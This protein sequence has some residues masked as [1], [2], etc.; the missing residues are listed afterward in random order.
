MEN[1]KVDVSIVIVSMNNITDLFLCLDC[2]IQ[3]THKVSYEIYVVAYLFTKNNLDLLEFKYPT[4]RIIESNEIRGYSENNNLA[5]RQVNNTYSIILND[6]TYF[7][8]PIIDS[9]VESFNKKPD[10]DFFSP[11]IADR[12]GLSSG[13]PPAR[14]YNYILNTLFR[15]NYLSKNDSKY[16]NQKGIYQTYNIAGCCFIVKTKVLKE[17]GFF[18]EHYFFCPEDL[19]LSTL[20]N[21]RGYK[22]YVNSSDVIHHIQGETI[23][24]TSTAT[25]PAMQKGLLLFYSK[26]S[27][28]PEIVLNLVALIGLMKY[29]LYWSF[30]F[31]IKSKTNKIKYGNAIKSIFSEKTPKEIFIKYYKS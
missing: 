1:K 30:R 10:A 29:W 22:C 26:F 13:R 19:E 25:F 31:D 16:V 11:V 20:A 9:L 5:L 3:N 17:L 18:N 2:I 23:G 14:A 12:T 15:M 27:K 8:T 6:D 7:D 24:K 4:V 21:K 28:C